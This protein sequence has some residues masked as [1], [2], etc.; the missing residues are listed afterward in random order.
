MVW[1]VIRFQDELDCADHWVWRGGSWNHNSTGKSVWRDVPIDGICG[2]DSLTLCEIFQL[3]ITT[4]LVDSFDEFSASALAAITMARSIG[5]AV[6]PLLGP[7]LYQHLGQ[8]WGN[9]VFAAVNLLCCAFPVLLFIFGAR[10]RDIFSS[11]DL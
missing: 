4:Y 11:D 3:S 8:G 1:L 9:S 6:V 5:G 2:E 10:W 7:V